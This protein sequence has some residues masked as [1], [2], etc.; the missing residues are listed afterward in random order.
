[1]SKDFV[2]SRQGTVSTPEFL[3]VCE[4]CYSDL[5][6]SSIKKKKNK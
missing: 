6:L 3:Q 4:M 1:M 2:R 5:E